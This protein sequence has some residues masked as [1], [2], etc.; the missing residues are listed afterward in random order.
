MRSGLITKVFE[1]LNITGYDSRTLERIYPKVRDNVKF[2]WILK[3][4]DKRTIYGSAI[5]VSE[6]IKKDK[7]LDYR[8]AVITPSNVHTFE[9]RYNIPISSYVERIIII[10]EKE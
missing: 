6:L 10:K 7:E 3:S 2:I 1:K 4:L 8:I 5:P 9:E